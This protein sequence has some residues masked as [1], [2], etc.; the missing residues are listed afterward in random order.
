MMIRS[1]VLSNFASW[2]LQSNNGE[3]NSNAYARSSPQ[4]HALARF[5]PQPC[6]VI[7]LGPPSKELVRNAM[8]LTDVLDCP[9]GASHSSRMPAS[10]M[11]A[12]QRS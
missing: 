1:K 3:D 12:I 9:V 8:R 4:V 5:F 2:D 10:R 6:I 11:I 7:H